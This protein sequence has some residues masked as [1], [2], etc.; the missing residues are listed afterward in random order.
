MTLYFLDLDT[1][2]YVLD[3]NFSDLFFLCTAVCI[4]GT[5]YILV[6]ITWTQ[7]HCLI[8]IIVYYFHTKLLNLFD[9]HMQVLQSLQTESLFLIEQ[10]QSQFQIMELMFVL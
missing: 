1:F 8:C 7:A 5:I 3:M 9:F 6:D 10:N 2:L 4:D